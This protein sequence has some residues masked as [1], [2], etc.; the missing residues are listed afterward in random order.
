MAVDIATYRA[1]TAQHYYKHLKTK[2]VTSLDY[3]E[4]YAWI[5]ILLLRSDDIEMNPGSHSDTSS[6]DSYITSDNSYIIKKT[7]FPW[8]TTTIKVHYTRWI[9]L[10]LNF[11]ILILFIYLRHGS[12]LI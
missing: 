2:G 11:L 3:F 7:N 1:R 12:V 4:Y 6:S 10:D 5:R 9:Y 8:Y